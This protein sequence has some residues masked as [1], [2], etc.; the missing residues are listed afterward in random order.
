MLI[1]G[2]GIGSLLIEPLIRE[3]MF[4]IGDGVVEG[5]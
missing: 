1:S 4:L 2:V 3:D 5:Q